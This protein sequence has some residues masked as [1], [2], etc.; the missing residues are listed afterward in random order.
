VARRTHS[1]ARHPY[2]V[3]GV[4]PLRIRHDVECFAS[5]YHT[6]ACPHMPRSFPPADRHPDHATAP[7]TQSPAVECEV[8]QTG[9]HEIYVAGTKWGGRRTSAGELSQTW[10]LCHARDVTRVAWRR[11]PCPSLGSTTP[12]HQRMAQLLGTLGGANP[13]PWKGSPR[14][15]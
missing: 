9:V 11:T 10:V 8:P 15:D 2:G 5:L 3:H 13:V 1:D 6:Y 14:S 12:A 7:C 4:S